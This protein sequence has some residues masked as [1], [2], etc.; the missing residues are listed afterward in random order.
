MSSGHPQACAILVKYWA[1]LFRNDAVQ[2]DE[3]RDMCSI[4]VFLTEDGARAAKYLEEMAD[5]IDGSQANLGCLLGLLVSG[6]R[7]RN[8]LTLRCCRRTTSHPVVI[9]IDGLDECDGQ[10]IQQEILRSIGHSNPDEGILSDGLDEDVG[11]LREAM[12]GGTT[13]SDLI[14]YNASQIYASPLLFSSSL[15]STQAARKLTF[16]SSQNV[17]HGVTSY[18]REPRLP[19]ALTGIGCNLV[20]P[21][22]Q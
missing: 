4:L 5:G 17:C 22:C 13:R 8:A 20:V 1:A 16:P 21:C 7:P 15:S 2:T 3:W 19:R 9:V 14:K 11:E 6:V 10:N 18:V 12:T